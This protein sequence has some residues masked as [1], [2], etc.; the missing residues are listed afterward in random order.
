MITIDIYK[1]GTGVIKKIAPVHNYSEAEQALE[2]YCRENNVQ[3]VAKEKCG[4]AHWN[5]LSDG[6]EFDYC[7]E[8]PATGH[9]CAAKGY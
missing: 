4:D 2:K 6:T 9:E 5:Y 7:P 1:K 8:Y 3:V